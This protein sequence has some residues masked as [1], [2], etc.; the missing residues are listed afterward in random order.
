MLIYQLANGNEMDTPFLLIAVYS[1]V[2]VADPCPLPT[3]N[4]PFI[5]L[6][7]TNTEIIFVLY[8][9]L[10]HLLLLLL[11]LLLSESISVPT[12]KQQLGDLFLLVTKTMDHTIDPIMMSEIKMY[13]VDIKM[14]MFYLLPR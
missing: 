1:V 9:L 12:T 14:M 6:F 2:V 3:T 11:L 10:L 4:R 5:I 8:F 7:K 13:L